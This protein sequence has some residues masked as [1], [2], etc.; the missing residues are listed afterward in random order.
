MEIQRIKSGNALELRLAGRFD[1][2]GAQQLD[3]ALA[4]AL[5]GGDLQLRLDLAEITYVSSS[6]IGVLVRYQQRLKQLGGALAISAVS[7]PVRRVLDMARLGALLETAPAV[8]TPVPPA[9]AAPPPEIRIEPPRLEILPLAPGATLRLSAVGDPDLLAGRLFVEDDARLLRPPDSGFAIGL[10]ASGRD[11]EACRHRFGEFLALAGAAV[12]QP[13]DGSNVPDQ[14][15]APARLLTL[16]SLVCE[17]SLSHRARFEA[18]GPG[19]AVSLEDLVG[20]CLDATG[21]A[22]WAG[23]VFLAEAPAH[24]GAIPL[25]FLACGIAARASNPEVTTLLHPEGWSRYPAGRFHAARFGR[26]LPALGADLTA[27][28]RA[29]FDAGPLRDV[30]VPRPDATHFTRGACWMGP[31]SEIKTER[32]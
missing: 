10:G 15:L 6:G 18:A 11:F 1:E 19:A 29:V 12:Y 32:S 26:A 2:Y 5:T 13:C 8:A 20:S 31:I 23:M 7:T 14:L 28:C 3:S 21:T 25:L 16:Y 22:D 9:P 4:A 30:V 27:C 17:G 24:T